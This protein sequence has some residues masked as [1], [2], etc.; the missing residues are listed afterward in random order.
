[1]DWNSAKLLAKAYVDSALRLN[2]DLAIAHVVEASIAMFFEW[3]W[4]TAEHAYRRAIELDPGSAEAWDGLGWFLATIR[5][6]K[7]EEAIA[8][9]KRAKQLDPL[10]PIL[11][12]NLG[13]S[14]VVAGRFEEA[15]REFKAAL[16]LEPGFYPS[17]ITLAEAYVEQGRYADAL[18]L[19]ED[20]ME[21]GDNQA[22]DLAFMGIAYAL[23]GRRAEAEE[24]LHRLEDEPEHMSIARVAMAALYNILGHSE[25][26]VELI[27]E[28]YDLRDPWFP[29]YIKH[30]QLTDLHADPRVAAILTE[31]ELPLD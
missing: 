15:E 13:V 6:G 12:A 14:Y 24:I 31:L 29:W 11:M 16:K 30:N 23:A 17:R 28:D 7:E 5:A 9:S 4:D 22:G 10:S 3:D 19:Y 25:R 18:T 26:A 27:L 8:A 1:M 21:T 2:P 20:L